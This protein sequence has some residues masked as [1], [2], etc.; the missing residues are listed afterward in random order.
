MRLD[1]FRLQFIHER[2]MLYRYRF[3]CIRTAWNVFNPRTRVARGLVWVKSIWA[4]IS[5]LH[6]QKIRKLSYGIHFIWRLWHA[7]VRPGGLGYK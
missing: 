3:C 6:I 2:E 5:V 1:K 7:E 4:T